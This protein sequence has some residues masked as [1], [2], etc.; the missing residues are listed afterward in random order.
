MNLVRPPRTGSR[1]P[2]EECR[3]PD[4]AAEP[5]E[6]VGV[7]LR[8]PVNA[9]FAPG[10]GSGT[11]TIADD[12]GRPPPPPSPTLTVDAPRASSNSI[13]RTSRSRPV[14]LIGGLPIGRLQETGQ[15]T[16]CYTGQAACS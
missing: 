16:Y 15:S 6:T 7:S 12:D 1:F 13:V 9:D 2:E 10:G 11:E 14:R 8:N 3:N 5:D 4:G